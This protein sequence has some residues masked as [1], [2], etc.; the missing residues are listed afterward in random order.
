MNTVAAYQP[1]LLASAAALTAVPMDQAN[2]LLTAWGHYLAACQ[3]PFGAEGWVLDIAGRPV[4]VAV[5]AST[6]S[7]TVAD[8]S[9]TEVVELAR[10]CSAPEAR[11][12]TRPMLRL[13]REICA[14][15]WRYWPV[16]AAVTY[17]ANARHDGSLYRF[18]GWTRVHSRAGAPCGPNA[19]WSKQ[20][21]PGSPAS[22]SKTL[23]IWRYDVLTV[24]A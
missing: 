20:R 12:A 7:P 10:L 17:S 21:A 8:L 24:P 19:T 2:R 9:R 18:D 4:S 14:P 23:W 13:W 3:R 15:A 11:W 22:G 1:A 16:R 6:V 5:S